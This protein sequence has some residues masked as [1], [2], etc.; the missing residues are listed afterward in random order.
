M[1]DDS[2][3][4]D[5]NNPAEIRAVYLENLA[6]YIE[7]LKNRTKYGGM[8]KPQLLNNPPNNK[9]PKLDSGG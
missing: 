3:V 7:K 4:Q 6:R 5:E 1:G 9:M 8:I 2:K